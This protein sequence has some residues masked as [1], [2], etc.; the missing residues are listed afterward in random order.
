MDTKFKPLEELTIMDDYIFGVVMCDKDNL[1][2]LLE[3]ILKV[4]IVELDFIERQKTE[5]EGYEF[6]GV[7]L[8]LYV[9]D[10]QGHVFNVEV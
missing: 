3:Y 7:R 4:N 5:K 1:T 2:S 9:K 10:D 8:N 6:H